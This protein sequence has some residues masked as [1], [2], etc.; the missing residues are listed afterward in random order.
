MKRKYF[1]EASY[2]WQYDELIK[3]YPIL[4]KYPIKKF[5]IKLGDMVHNAVMIEIEE[6]E[7]IKLCNEF[8]CKSLVL[9]FNNDL[10][11]EYDYPSIIIYDGYIE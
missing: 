5:P 8:G 10:Y 3:L 1:I 9:D 7:I 2:R 4:L 6:C 11:S